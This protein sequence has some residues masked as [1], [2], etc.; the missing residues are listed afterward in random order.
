VGL[1]FI[2]EHVRKSIPFV[3]AT[4]VPPAR[5]R[6]AHASRALTPPLAR[7]LSAARR[8]A[9]ATPPKRRRCASAYTPAAT[10]DADPKHHSCA[11]APHAPSR[12][13]RRLDVDAGL[14]TMKLVRDVGSPAL[15]RR[16][17]Q[18]RFRCRSELTAVPLG[19]ALRRMSVAMASASRSIQRL[20]KGT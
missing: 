17:P 7:P 4:K 18:P 2:Q 10:A 11:A 1:Y 20:K 12:P 15:R 3:I 9:S 6:G 19:F 8:A 16:A 13:V 5:R 14:D